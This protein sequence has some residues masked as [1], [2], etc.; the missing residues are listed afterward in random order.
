MIDLK[1]LITTY[2]QAFLN[3]AGGEVELMD[4][5][6]N[7]RELGV[8]ADIYGPSSCD[9]ATYD[10]IL[11][12]S[13]HGG[14]LD[15]LRSIER[16][17]KRIILW[18]NLW[19]I[20]K[21]STTQL[22]VAIEYVRLSDAI[23]FKSKAEIENVTK[24]LE[25]PNDKISII[26]AGVDPCFRQPADLNMFKTIYKVDDYILWLGII[27]KNKNQLFCI[28]SL[29][30]LE[31]PIVFVGNYR[32]KD[33]Y[34]ACIK[35]SPKHF[36]FLPSMPSKSEI[37]RSALKTCKLYLEV[38]LEPPGISALEAGLA[39]VPMVL[40]DDAWSREH[41]QDNI[42]FVNP[43]SKKSIRE[44]VRKALNVKKYHNIL[45]DIKERHLY[46]RCLDP[47]ISI[48]QG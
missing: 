24:Y 25:I 30:D 12:F 28:E 22:N 34:D 9:L 32:E 42:I 33:Y 17:G 43:S 45:N 19:W 46:P 48:I 8:K 14:G 31:I 44:G 16:V 41:F 20:E 15:L 40:S 35:A 47:L 13:M 4:V 7:L 39:G 11:H 37:L 23:V 38:P 2:H 3:K 6:S 10:A 27:E 26:P 29:Y 1:V 18:P 5:A 36:V 21:P